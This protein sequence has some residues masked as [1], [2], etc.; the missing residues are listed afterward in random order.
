MSA[1][2]TLT[3]GEMTPEEQAI[4]DKRETLRKAER[5]KAKKT[6]SRD[7]GVGRALGCLSAVL[8]PIIGLPIGAWVGSSIG[9]QPA[10]NAVLDFTG[11]D[12]DLCG[13]VIGFF[14]GLLLAIAVWRLSRP[15]PRS[16]P[17]SRMRVRLFNR[18]FVIS[19]FMTRYLDEHSPVPQAP[20]GRP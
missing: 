1:G 9:P 4:R 10:P 13:A 12:W 16:R 6:T 20:Q 19:Q 17:R 2:R 5:D 18:G 7:D 11:L 3:E 15:T 14:V 8:M